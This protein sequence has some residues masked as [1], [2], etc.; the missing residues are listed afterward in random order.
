MVAIRICPLC[1][2]KVPA[3][4]VVTQSDNIQC[5]Q[6]GKTLEVSRPS[7]VLGGLVGVLSGWLVYRLTSS[8]GEGM[9]AWA[10]PMAYAIVAYAMVSPVFLMLTADLVVKP[11]QPYAEPVAAPIGHGGH[12]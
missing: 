8:G 4:T 11:E 5:P 10:L 1:F 3:T 6:C 12:H 7:R 2:G 9:L